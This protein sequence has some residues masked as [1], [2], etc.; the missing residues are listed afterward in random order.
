MNETADWDPDGLARVQRI[1]DASL[2]RAG[3]VQRSFFGKPG[4]VLPARDFLETWNSIYMCAVATY[5]SSRWPH[6]AAVKLQFDRSASLNMF[7][8]LDTVRERDL[9]TSPRL[10]LQKQRDD[11][12]VLTCYARA[13]ARAT[14]PITDA[15]GRSHVVLPLEPVRMYGIGP[16]VSGPLAAASS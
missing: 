7:L 9:Q 16:Y 12:T 15:R 2:D 8:Y 4:R 14:A 13:G 10:A 1:L 6:L 3:Q 5:G 11:G